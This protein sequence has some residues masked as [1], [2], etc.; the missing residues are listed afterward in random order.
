MHLVALHQ[1]MDAV[2]K[3]GSHDIMVQSLLRVTCQQAQF[4]VQHLNLGLILLAA[5]AQGL[6]FGFD[7]IVVSQFFLT[8]QDVH[9]DERQTRLQPIPDG[10]FFLQGIIGQLV[11]LEGTREVAAVLLQL[12][13]VL[14][15]HGHAPADISLLVEFQRFAV[16]H[17]SRINLPDHALDVAQMTIVQGCAMGIVQIQ[18]G[19]QG[20]TQHA[21]GSPEVAEFHL[22]IADAVERRG[23]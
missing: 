13:E 15:T 19:L 10:R 20:N 21:V 1:A 7:K 12:A 22:Y 4:V 16:I 18:L 8:Q 9:P 6:G 23:A 17:P 14:M 3:R 2:L 5:D 11:F